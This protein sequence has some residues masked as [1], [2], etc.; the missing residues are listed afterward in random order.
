MLIIPLCLIELS[1]HL[2]VVSLLDGLRKIFQIVM[3]VPALVQ[4]GG[5]GIRDLLHL[6]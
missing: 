2:W 5:F 4:D 1:M 3:P 6:V